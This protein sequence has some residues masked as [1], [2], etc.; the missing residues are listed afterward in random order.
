MHGKTVIITGANSG[1]GLASAVELARRGAHVVMACRNEERGRKAWETAVRESGSDQ[2]ELMLC[3]LGSLKSIR[4]FAGEVTERYSVVDVLLNN[5]GVVSLKREMTADGFESMLGVNHLGH[6]LLTNLLL[7]P[8]KRAEEGRIVNVSSGAYKIGKFHR[9]PSLARGYN[10]AKGYAQSKLANVLFTKELAHRLEGS[11]VTANCLH[12]GAVATNIGV[13]R[14]TG[15]GKSLVG[16]MRPF[17][18][19]A[20]QGAETAIYLSCSPEVKGVSGQFFYKKQARPLTARGE[21]QVA[22]RRLW[23]WSEEQVGLKR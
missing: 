23:E 9:D 8:L 1:M 21:D 13:D 2:L 18:L 16:L 17:F 3:D 20:E 12:P 6:F 15:F 14:N 22:A 11:R 7:E 10:V 4:R 5:A 19:T